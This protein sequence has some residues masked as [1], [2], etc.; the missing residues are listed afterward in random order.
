MVVPPPVDLDIDLLGTPSVFDGGRDQGR[1][2]GEDC[3]RGCK[4]QVRDAKHRFFV[5]DCC[6]SKKD[7]KSRATSFRA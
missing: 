6:Y 1:V 4:V 5:V 7:I 3:V 2:E